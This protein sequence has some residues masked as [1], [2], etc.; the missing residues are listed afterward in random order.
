MITNLLNS[1]E[2]NHTYSENL[3]EIIRKMIQSQCDERISLKRLYDELINKKLRKVNQ[4]IQWLKEQTTKIID[5]E[6]IKSSIEI[7]NKIKLDMNSVFN[8][9]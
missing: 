7:I 8:V 1:F 5:A 9:K 3:I 2:I 4:K 6:H